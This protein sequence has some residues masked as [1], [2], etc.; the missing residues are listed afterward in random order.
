MTHNHFSFFW[1]RHNH[2][3]YPYTNKTPDILL[4]I[5]P[6][7]SSPECSANEMSTQSIT[8]NSL[9]TPPCR[10]HNDVNGAIEDNCIVIRCALTKP[11]VASRQPP[12]LFSCSRTQIITLT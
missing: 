3:E 2:P 11:Q 10:G 7:E 1:Q 5:Y 12:F 4:D 6:A 9:S 8:C